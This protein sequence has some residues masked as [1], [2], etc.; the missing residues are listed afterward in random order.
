VNGLSDAVAVAAGDAHTCA[1]RAGGSVVC[2]GLNLSGQLGLGD[3][4]D[5]LVPTAVPGLTGVSR[6]YAFAVGTC[7]VTGGSE[8]YCWGAAAGAG[9]L[10]VTLAPVR[11]PALDGLQGRVA[12]EGLLRCAALA[13]LDVGCWGTG[14]DGPSRATVTPVAGAPATRQVAVGVSHVCA[15]SSGGGVHCWGR[16]D[17]GQL[18]DGGR[19][20]RAAP[21]ATPDLTGMVDIVA[22]RTRSCAVSATGAV[23]CWGDS[24]GGLLWRAA[25]SAPTRLTT[26]SGAA[27]GRLV[28]G[29]DFMCQLVA[30]TGT[31]QCWGGNGSGQLGNGST[32]GG[33][34]PGEVKGLAEL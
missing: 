20:A 2:W 22:R 26:V 6:L 29:S 24:L 19:Q 4:V 5:R 30:R 3:Q 32:Q 23:L 21:R 25:T 33:P 31:V 10:A 12:G 14:I 27:A 9:S 17:F 28:M 15:L 11:V 13:S 8:V 7:A 1:L 16:N 18:A 34:T